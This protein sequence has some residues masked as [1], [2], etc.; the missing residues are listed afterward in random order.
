MTP[1]KDIP[2]V[3]AALL[4]LVAGVAGTLGAVAWIDKPFPGFLVLENR[5]VASAGLSRW[6]ATEGGDIYQHQIVAVNGDPLA[7]VQALWSRVREVPVGT[8]LVYRFERAG[9]R[10][11]RTIATRRFDL[12]DFGLLFGAYLLNG[13][14]MGAAALGIRYL[15]GAHPLAKATVPLLLI[16]S[17]WG[18]TAM[19]LYGPYRLFR[20]HALCETL[21]FPAFLAMALGF[22]QPAR[23]S[24]RHPWTR[25]APYALAAGLA[26]VYQAGLYHP[27][28]YVACHLAANVGIG[29][30]VAVLIASQVGRFVRQESFEARQR[31]KV[32]ALG[33]AAAM[34]PPLVLTLGSALTGGKASQNV[35]AFTAFL[36][37]LAI[38]Y[39]VIRHNLLEVDVLVRRSLG[40]AVLT[41]IVTALYTGL[42]AGLDIVFRGSPLLDS[43]WFDAGFA[44][45]CLTL[46]LPLRDRVQST[47]DRVFFRTVYDFRHTIEKTSGRLAAVTDLQ[48]ISEELTVAVTE[49]LHPESTGLY[50]RRR[51]NDPL[52]WIGGDGEEPA[53]ADEWLPLADQAAGPFDLVA[54][55]LVVPFRTEGTLVGALWLGRRQSGKAYGGEDRRLLQVLANQ[56]AVAIQN[57]LTLEQLRRL[58]RDLEAKVEERTLELREKNARLRELS[59]TDMVT[60]LR[61]RRF[62]MEIL[63]R[64]FHRCRRHGGGFALLMVDL[65]HFKRVNDTHGHLAGDQVLK[66]VSAVA[67]GGLRASDVAGRYGGE[68]LLFVLPEASEEDAATLAER[69]R[70]LIESTP[71]P[72]E[73]GQLVELTVSIGVATFQRGHETPEQ[74]IAAADA[75]LYRAKDAGRNHVEIATASD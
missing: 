65:D 21:L 61:N 36:F 24:Q 16:S 63:T 10:F 20:L 11:E 12:T 72:L 56:G 60:G 54:G 26:L 64:E 28:T 49:A 66:Q 30:A 45:L 41:V 31:I 14:V 37:P 8:P 19:D 48:F 3:C 51:K 18:L 53:G 55:V 57:A 62:T 7:S 46:L 67:T 25:W 27:V 9:Q 44:A 4:V 68:E 5:V 40:Y 58:N 71:V 59:S 47:L 70:I 43:A 75:A 32:L 17:V 29:V 22:P 34:T 38:G 52:E 2:L 50:V 13:L 73:D 33:T 69:L 15:R 74:V 35:I 6:P 39:A 1:P 42:V 23:L